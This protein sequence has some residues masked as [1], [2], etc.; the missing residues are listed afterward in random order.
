M[1]QILGAFCSICLYALS[2]G[3]LA[4]AAEESATWSGDVSLGAMLVT[5]NANLQ[6]FNGELNLD[7]QLAPWRNR[8]KVSGLYAWNRELG[9][10]A[11]F[12]YTLLSQNDYAQ[13]DRGYLFNKN[14]YE[15]DES[16]GLDYSIQVSVGYG[17]E[18]IQR[19]RHELEVELGVGHWRFQEADS[20]KVTNG[21]F[22]EISADY[23][24]HITSAVSFNQEV[25]GETGSQRS[26]ARSESGVNIDVSRQLDLTLSHEMRYNSPVIGDRQP[27]DSFTAI[28]LGYQF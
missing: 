13:G 8:F 24:W 12:R 4:Q 28:K 11:T 5:G 21:T 19:T 15:H 6:R 10:R 9:E 2:S 27:V 23:R 18:L 20:G 26:V 17:H 14:R 22:A 25:S 16:S 1:R 3:I 7:R